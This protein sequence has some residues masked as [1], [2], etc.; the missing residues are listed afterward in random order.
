MLG[1]MADESPRRAGPLALLG[2]GLLVAATGVGAGDLAGAGIAGARLGYAVLWAVLLG[3]A[4]KL[5][6]TE[7]L[8]RW[9]IATGRTVLEGAMIWLGRPVQVLLA[10]YLL[11]WT[12]F[13]G[14]ALI[15]ACGVTA[16]ALLP[17]PGSW[18]IPGLG[19]VLGGKE[20]YGVMCSV[21]G[22]VLAW[23]GG[24]RLFE[25]VMGVCVALMFGV[26][27]V[28]AVLMGP[29]WG[30]VAAGLV[31]PRVPGGP[32]GASWT[33]GLIGGVG[34]TLTVI[35]YSYWM[36]EAGRDGREHLRLARIDAAVGY[37]MTAVFGVAMVVIA[38]G[39]ELSGSG[40]GLIVNLADRLGER[41]GSVGRLAF[42]VGAFAAVFSSLLGVWQAVPY[43]YADFWGLRRCVGRGASAPEPE[44]V[45]TRSGVYRIVL[46]A[47]AVVPLAGLFVRF[48][49]VQ[50]WYAVYGAFF[51]PGLAAALLVLN[52]R[53]GLVGELRNRWWMS[54]ALVGVVVFFVVFAAMEGGRRLGLFG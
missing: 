1:A 41:L 51:L 54:A 50:K 10:L 26:V 42:L 39:I 52:G 31:V 47:I 43:V 23:F 16:A 30:A 40:A 19:V 15:S 35:C 3:A 49:T 34:G 22:L 8:A 6:I 20:V 28:T 11:P 29:D 53:R 2:P 5:L 21:L 12:F 25:R 38:S 48:A 27:V 4:M 46:V 17:S 37:S 32:E 36:R 45:S 18:E 13:T 33:I 44:P 24:F 14:G 9:Q 7:N